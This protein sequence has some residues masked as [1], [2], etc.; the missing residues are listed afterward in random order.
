MPVRLWRED[1]ASSRSGIYFALQV[2]AGLVIP[3]WLAGWDVAEHAA[4]AHA[5]S[6]D[7]VASSSWWRFLFDSHH[8]RFVP[9]AAGQLVC[10]GLARGCTRS[11]PPLVGQEPGPIARVLS[12]ARAGLDTGQR[13]QRNLYFETSDSLRFEFVP[14]SGGMLLEGIVR[15][16][17]RAFRAGC[18]GGWKKMNWDGKLGVRARKVQA[19]GARLRLRWTAEAAVGYCSASPAR[20]GRMRPSLHGHC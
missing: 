14:R 7:F 2:N 10:F 20:D 19:G 18:G 11:G 4:L 12:R 3:L 13:F 9:I 1:P 6:S 8:G 5:G 16:S 15:E 17:R